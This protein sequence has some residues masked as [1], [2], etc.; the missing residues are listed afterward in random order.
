[1]KIALIIQTSTKISGCMMMGRS[2]ICMVTSEGYA[3]LIN[4]RLR[5]LFKRCFI[6][7]RLS[8]LKLT[9]A[10]RQRGDNR[11]QGWL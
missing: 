11:S 5:I 4:W 2:G 7:Y 8:V 9:L 1:M 3:R 6:K 10:C